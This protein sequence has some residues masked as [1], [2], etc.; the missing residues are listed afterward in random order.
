VSDITPLV[1]D[2][3]VPVALLLIILW[4]GARGKWVYGRT[5]EEMRRRAERY[6][7]LA[8]RAVGAAEGGTE[9]AKRLADEKQKAA[10]TAAD[11]AAYQQRVAA[12]LVAEQQQQAADL[13][14][15][16]VVKALRGEEGL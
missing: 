11:L 8:L 5:Y 4:T 9:L 12:D 14:A 3:G 2:F 10:D 15:D 13:V 6:E 16:A 1:R 7:D